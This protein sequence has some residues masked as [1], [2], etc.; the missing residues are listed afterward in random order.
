MGLGSSRNPEGENSTP[1]ILQ[2]PPREFPTTPTETL[3]LSPA[4]KYSKWK[5]LDNVSLAQ[6]QSLIRRRANA[7]NISET[8]YP[9]GDKHT[10]STFVDQTHTQNLLLTRCFM[11][12][13]E[14]SSSDSENCANLTNEPITPVN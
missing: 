9:T 10:I 7:R 14:S 12:F 6:A 3:S 2:L 4:A 1:N 13:H 8:P 5:L 11:S